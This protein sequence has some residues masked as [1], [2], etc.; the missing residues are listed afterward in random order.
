MLAAYHNRTPDEDAKTLVSLTSEML[1]PLSDNDNIRLCCVLPI[2]STI[3]AGNHCLNEIIL[4]PLLSPLVD[5]ALARENHEAAR[6]AASSC[7]FSII[8]K[9]LTEENISIV[10]RKLRELS[11]LIFSQLGS[12]TND[13]FDLPSLCDAFNLVAL[14]GASSACRGITFSAIS[15][16]IATLLVTMACQDS[17]STAGI[18]ATVTSAKCNLKEVSNAKKITLSIITGNAF[19]SMLSLNNGGPFWRQRISQVVLPKL[20]PLDFTCRHLEHGRLLCACHIV[21]CVPARALG[22]KRFLELSSI[23]INGLETCVSLS[24]KKSC[25]QMADHSVKQMLLGSL[26]K[27]VDEYPQSVRAFFC[28]NGSSFNFVVTWLFNFLSFVHD[29]RLQYKA[30]G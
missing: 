5:Y 11:L 28:L 23:I 6:S 7:I 30:P 13:N 4:T 1:P 14:I 19:G 8:S 24:N 25:N 12:Q 16:D 9:N 21:C 27:V 22:E 18:F 3:L 2:L 15:N 17:F 10:E 26:M 20:I 29:N